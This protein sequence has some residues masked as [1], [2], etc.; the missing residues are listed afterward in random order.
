MGE[1]NSS[2]III[3][4]NQNKIPDESTVSKIL[5]NIN[6]FNS[7]V[8]NLRSINR[9]KRIL[10]RYMERYKQEPHNQEIIDNI[11]TACENLKSNM[12]SVARSCSL[13]LLYTAGSV[14]FFYI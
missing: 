8:K 2:N 7:A 14:F 3:T 12:W 10:A 5:D 11:E 1:I 9:D 4:N 13:G 6:A